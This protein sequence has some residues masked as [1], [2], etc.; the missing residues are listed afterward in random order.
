MSQRDLL[1]RWI[2]QVAQVIAALLR[3][4][5]PVDLAPARQQVDAAL[6]QHLGPLA[7]LVP[8]L[9]VASAAALLADPDRIFAYAR[10]LLLAAEVD[11]ASGHADGGAG[12][13]R[14]LDFAAAALARAPERRPEWEAWLAAARPPAE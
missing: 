4:P 7:T 6:A 13:Q 8:T 2:E 12:R 9:D 10:L 14:A 5:P 11:L 3:G 1:H